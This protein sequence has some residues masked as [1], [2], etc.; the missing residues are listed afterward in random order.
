MTRTNVHCDPS[1]SGLSINCLLDVLASF[2]P[3]LTGAADARIL[4]VQQDSRRIEPGDLFVARSGASANGRQFVQ[5]AID[6]GA[7]AVL[8]DCSIGELPP[9][10]VPVICVSQARRALAFA[11][12]AVHGY[13]SKQLGLVGIT[14][15]NGKTTTVA[16]V[17]RGLSV[18]GARPARLGTTGFAF[19]GSEEESNLTT[20]EADEITRLIARVVRQSGT[21]FIMEA[22]SHALDQGRV[23]ALHFEVAAFSNLTQDHLDHHGTMAAYEAAKQRLFTELAPT[24]AVIN[25]DD[26]AGERFAQIARVQ[27]LVR[28]G[29]SSHCNVQPVSVTLNAQ[30]MGGEIRV[31]DRRV[32][33]QTRLVGDHNLE[34][35]L[36]ALG[37]LHALEVDLQSA[38][39]AFAGDFGVPGRLE[40]CDGLN[41]D[42]VVLVDYAHTPDALERVLQAVKRFA[43]GSVHCVF[44][45]GGDRDP[46]KRP[47]MGQAVGK[48]AD[49]A[50]ITN[51]N[52]RTESPDLIASAIEPG[53][54]QADIQYSVELDRAVAIHV[55]ILAAKAGD[56]VVIA[57]KGHEPYQIVGT[58]KRPFDDRAQAREA[59]VVRRGD[60]S[61][62][63]GARG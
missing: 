22:S 18:A 47:L 20:P 57:G 58:V 50:T 12:E 42:I 55:A 8:V 53:L 61:K 62:R 2:Q 21:H 33:L 1:S 43:K 27:Q 29:R 41:D 63:A 44:G 45:C 34:N 14:G 13:P 4:G 24:K 10:S 54:R 40:R 16:L 51:D 11:A 30:G 37:I 9:L 52:P 36:L 19:C 39:R 35:V 48:W 32:N 59:L 15:T 26:P 17:E 46:K 56:V 7:A 5:A 25:V 23:D 6:H 3:V 60:H 38:I 49:R 28:V 31:D